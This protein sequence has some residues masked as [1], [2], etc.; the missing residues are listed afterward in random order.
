MA[1]GVGGG[2][3]PGRHPTA[4]SGKR[5]RAGTLSP[6]WDT[7]SVCLEYIQC[8]RLLGLAPS[9][10]SGHV[11]CQGLCQGCNLSFYLSA[12]RYHVFRYIYMCACI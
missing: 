12:S 10:L 4:A 11:G 6:S 8:Q 5:P 9:G 1:G 7:W 3:A 2:G